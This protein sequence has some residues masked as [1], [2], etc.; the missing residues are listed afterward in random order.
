MRKEKFD[1][2]NLR[3][4]IV[5][6]RYDGSIDII[7]IRQ[8]KEKDRVIGYEYYVIP[9]ESN[10]G[11]IAGINRKYVTDNRE[12]LG[13]ALIYN[14]TKFKR[15]S[16]NVIGYT[17]SS[18][19]Y[20][21]NSAYDKFITYNG[22]SL[23]EELDKRIQKES[24]FELGVIESAGICRMDIIPSADARYSYVIVFNTMISKN[25]TVELI[26]STGNKRDLTYEC[27]VHTVISGGDTYRLVL[28]ELVISITDDEIYILRLKNG[29][30]M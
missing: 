21:D 8:A 25:D 11:F 9:E 19:H 17:R 12:A 5:I 27:D 16:R 7:D 24:A 20:R 3:D 1:I 18:L 26:D 23:K 10:I 28:N 6:H 22:C 15:K 4:C 30:L 29:T 13:L 2:G 14:N